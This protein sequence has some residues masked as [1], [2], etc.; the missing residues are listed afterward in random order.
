MSFLGKKPK[1]DPKPDTSTAVG[2]R[3]VE[4]DD[5][6]VPASTWDG[7]QWIGTHAWEKKKNV[8]PGH[9]FERYILQEPR[10]ST[11]LA[12]LIGVKIW[13]QQKSHRSQ[14][15]QTLCQEGTS[16]RH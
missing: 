13:R 9:K 14:G 3:Q 16:S 15:D 4:H 11:L 10:T 6:F 1:E 7:L 12:W 8:V 5:D 2:P